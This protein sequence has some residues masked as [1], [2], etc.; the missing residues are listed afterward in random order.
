M[1]K[2]TCPTSAEWH[3]RSADVR[4]IIRQR[5]FEHEQDALLA[6]VDK[7][8]EMWEL[9]NIYGDD[10]NEEVEEVLHE[11]VEKALPILQ[12]LVVHV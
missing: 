1:L 10:P 5:Y 3:H 7:L 11:L 9:L 6:L 2:H 12:G 4:A 8:D